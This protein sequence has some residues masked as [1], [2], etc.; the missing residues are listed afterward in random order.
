V[1]SP[2]EASIDEAKAP[3]VDDLQ[4]TARVHKVDSLFL[5]TDGGNSGGCRE[6]SLETHNTTSVLTSRAQE[7][8]L[9]IMANHSLVFAPSAH[10]PSLALV[11]G[12]EPAAGT[13]ELQC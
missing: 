5:V 2:W 8:V 1:R 6:S 7:F 4:F 13:D 9:S 12:S 10:C 11:S 3:S